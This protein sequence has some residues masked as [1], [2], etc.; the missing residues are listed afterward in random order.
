M[1]LAVDHAQPHPG[2]GHFTV[3][4]H[5]VIAMGAASPVVQRSP[6]AG[7]ALTGKPITPVAARTAG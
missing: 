6:E 1:P 4:R 2:L 7:T 5:A 3:C